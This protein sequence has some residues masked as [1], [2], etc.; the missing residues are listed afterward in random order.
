MGDESRA[1][2]GD[3]QACHLEELQIGSQKHDIRLPQFMVLPKRG[4]ETA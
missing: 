1:L 3:A 2:C 4:C